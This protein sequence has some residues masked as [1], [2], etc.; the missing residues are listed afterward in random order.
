[1]ENARD[2]TNYKPKN[3]GGN[4][5]GRLARTGIMSDF[6]TET[7]MTDILGIPANNW[8][9]FLKAHTDSNSQQDIQKKISSITKI[10]KSEEF[11]LLMKTLRDYMDE[12]PKI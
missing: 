3:D 6:V 1:M 11:D 9:L 8:R 12:L 10:L 7:L 2:K 5:F 4:N